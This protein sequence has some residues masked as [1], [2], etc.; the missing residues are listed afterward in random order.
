MRMFDFTRENRYL[1]GVVCAAAIAV[2][3][4]SAVAQPQ[5]VESV[6]FGRY[7]DDNTK[8]P[9]LRAGEKRV[10]FIGNSI[11]ECWQ[12]ERPEFFKS[13]GYVGRGIG[14]QT[15]YNLLLRFRA[16]ALNLKPTVIVLGIGGNDI[17]SGDEWYDE[18]RTFGNVV[19][20]VELARANGV[21]IVLTSLL[22]AAT[23]PWNPAA[24]G[25]PDKIDSL[26][27]RISAYAKANKIPYADYYT[28]LVHPGDRALP[29]TFS[30]DGV[31]PT[32]SGYAIMEPVIQSILKKM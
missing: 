22:P 7:A 18:D 3:A 17:A 19:S 26:N 25:V 20:M 21:K 13:N 1:R 2:C 15:S 9:P 28:P 16:D 4:V 24:T 14:G 31:H 32:A 30:D 6:Q 8:L 12:N 11:T 27:R 10:V 29:V 23:Y 5:V